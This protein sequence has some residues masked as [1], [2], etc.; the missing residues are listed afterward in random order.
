MLT[1]EEKREKAAI[2]AETV[3]GMTYAEWSRLCVAIDKK[4]SLKAS[5]VQFDNSEDIQKAILLEL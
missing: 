3:K 5:R 2:I 1:D 4:F